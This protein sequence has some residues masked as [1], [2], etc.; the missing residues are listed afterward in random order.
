M[1]DWNQQNWPLLW[2]RYHARSQV[3]YCLHVLDLFGGRYEHGLSSH[4]ES[5]CTSHRG[6]A[7]SLLD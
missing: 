2:H 1:C 3:V 7:A 4:L 5:V 6:A